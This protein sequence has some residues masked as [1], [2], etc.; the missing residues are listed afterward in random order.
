M[1]R[2]IPAD[3]AA[4]APEPPLFTSFAGDVGAGAGIFA[5]ALD[6]RERGITEVESSG[7]G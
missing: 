3:K 1:E 6:L 5:G 4:S 2:A 7:Q